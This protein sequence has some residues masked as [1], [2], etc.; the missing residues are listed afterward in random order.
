MEQS[1]DTNSEISNQS[2]SRKIFIF[3]VLFNLFFLI[4]GIF[5]VESGYRNRDIPYFPLVCEFIL[6]GVLTVYFI[7][8]TLKQ[9]CSYKKSFLLGLR[10]GLIIT[11]SF[12][13]F[14]IKDLLILLGEDF[15][16]G[17]WQVILIFFKTSMIIAIG[18]LSINFVYRWLGSIGFDFTLKLKSKPEEEEPIT[19]DVQN[20]EKP[21]MEDVKKDR[22]SHFSLSNFIILIMPFVA[23]CF[24]HFYIHINIF[25]RAIGNN[26]SLKTA[27]FIE[28]IILVI[29]TSIYFKRNIILEKGYISA[30]VLGLISGTIAGYIS[31]SI[32]YKYTK[33]MSLK[34]LLFTFTLH[35]ITLGICYIIIKFLARFLKTPEHMESIK[36]TLEFQEN[37]YNKV[38]ISNKNINDAH[39]HCQNCG[40]IYK[41]KV[42]RCKVCHSSKVI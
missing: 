31:F 39:Y 22:I 6:L 14:F 36:P 32:S 17:L 5:F 15:L 10:N 29:L 21:K 28:Y 42:H 2:G 7:G 25:G 11:M 26:N 16:I 19:T 27:L 23:Y 13:M 35:G 9:G 30:F 3:V 1:D 20:T 41:R 37:I 8:H 18:Y 4:C 38:K 34:G 12:F 33:Y 40:M 24:I